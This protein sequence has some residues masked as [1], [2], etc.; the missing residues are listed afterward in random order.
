[1]SQNSKVCGHR[2]D[3]LAYFNINF[4][5]SRVGPNRPLAGL[6]CYSRRLAL[7]GLSNKKIIKSGCGKRQKKV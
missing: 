4:E 6:P 3:K 2:H 7:T 5:N 1:M